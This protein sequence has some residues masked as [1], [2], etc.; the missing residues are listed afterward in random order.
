MRPGAVTSQP[1]R[2]VIAR[3]GITGRRPLA[4]VDAAGRAEVTELGSARLGGPR[5]RAQCAW[6][7]RLAVL[8]SD[9]RP[10][11]KCGMT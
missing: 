2:A 11:G 1:A 6:W 7:G 10:C 4:G 9:F 8:G 3:G 5:G